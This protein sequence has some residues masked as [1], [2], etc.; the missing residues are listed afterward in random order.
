MVT[1]SL[2]M[3]VKDEEENLPRCLASV[4]GLVD[5][6]V[7]VDTG[8][9]DRTKER[10][11]QFTPL[12][13]DFPWIDDFS[14]ARNFAFSKGTMDYCMWLDADDVLEEEAQSGFLQ[15]KEELSPETDVVMMR[16]HTAFDSGGRPTFTYYRERLIRREAGLLWQG[17]VHE[18]ITPAGVVVY[19][20]L[21][22]THR[23]TGPGEPERNLRIFES[24]LRAG[25]S[26]SPRE[27]FY[28][29]RELTYHG[30]DGEA[31]EVL[32]EFLQSEEGW[33]ENK[34][35]AC[36]TLAG[37]YSRLGREELALEALFKS[38]Q[39]GPPRAE[40]CC[41]L[42]QWFFR[43]EEN[44]TAAFWY[45]LAL[46]RPRADDTGAFVV[47]DCYDYLPCIQLCL[48]YYRMGQ[49]QRARDY[50]ERAGQ[51]KPEDPSYL[52]NRDFF[53]RQGESHRSAEESS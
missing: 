41:E 10:A 23:K 30:R 8:S 45:E 17:A 51:A 27:Q 11:A 53:A 19:S 35:E 43:R 1:V 44:A 22:V 46:T 16:Y 7:I 5:E 2:C 20:Q 33:L 38:L 36:R 32:R 26:L 12:I 52:Y 48:C 13:Y 37:C 34:M 18:A 4:Q 42:G 24:L 47:P 39:F 29:A 25:K 31:T 50:N 15:L 21:S 14:A 49:L 3:I 40:L 6:I 9:R 28:Y